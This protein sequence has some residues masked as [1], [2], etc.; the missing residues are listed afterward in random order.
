MVA[1]VGLVTTGKV[2]LILFCKRLVDGAKLD[3]V[4][5]LELKLLG[6]QKGKTGNFNDETGP[7]F[8]NYPFLSG[9]NSKTLFVESK[10]KTHP[11]LLGQNSRFTPFYRVKIRISPLFVGTKFKIYP[12]LLGHSIVN[13]FE[14]PALFLC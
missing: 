12:F 4:V 8:K 5:F 13:V 10:F 11:F 3:L 9:Q 1:G 2:V 7:K 14:F 6:L